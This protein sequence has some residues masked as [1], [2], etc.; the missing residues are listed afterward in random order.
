MEFK[1]FPKLYRLSRDIIVTEKLDG[2]NAQVLIDDITLLDPEYVVYEK[3]GLGVVAGSRN[4]FIKPG[5]DNFGF[6]AWVQQNAEELLGLGI[7]QHFGEW[8]GKGIQR[9]YGL[10]E[11]RF[12]LFNTER[13][14]DDSVRP[15]CCHVVPVLY[16]GPMDTEAIDEQLRMLHDNFSVAAPGFDNPEGVVVFHTHS[17]HGYKKTLDNN[18]NH[19]WMNGD[20]S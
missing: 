2:T 12:S 5:A 14:S 3:D 15:A 7:G 19:K 4:R 9:G 6:A 13:W 1:E 8:W 17:R 11:K 20:G 10:E 18:D 16:S